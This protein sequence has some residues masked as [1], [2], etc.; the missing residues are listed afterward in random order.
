MTDTIV[1]RYPSHRAAESVKEKCRIISTGCDWRTERDPVEP[2]ER[3]RGVGDY[4]LILE[5][6]EPLL[7]AQTQTADLC[8]LQAEGL[9][10]AERLY[11]LNESCP[12]M[13]TWHL[14]DD[15]VFSLAKYNFTQQTM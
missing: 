15:N 12:L 11:N 5:T 4:T 6:S 1:A 9:V 2:S 13:Q 10:L 7:H 8:R 3:K 14:R